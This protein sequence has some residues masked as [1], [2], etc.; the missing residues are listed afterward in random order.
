[1]VFLEQESR[2]QTHCRAH[3]TDGQGA[4]RQQHEKEWHLLCDNAACK[5][6]NRLFHYE[7]F[8]NNG[9]W[10]HDDKLM[11]GHQEHSIL[12]TAD[13]KRDI[14]TDHRVNHKKSHDDSEDKIFQ[15]NC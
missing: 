9:N 8:Q 15:V 10:S 13:I 5:C 7:H 2:D 1:M 12:H 3:Q 6:H 4:T 14:I 11:K